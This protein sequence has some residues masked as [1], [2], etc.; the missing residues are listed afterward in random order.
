MWVL[1]LTVGCG[2]DADTGGGTTSTGQGTTEPTAGPDRPT[3]EATTG[4]EPTTVD[5]SG[6]SSGAPGTDGT[7][8]AAEPDAVALYVSSG[9]VVH[10]FD[11]DLDTGA[12]LLGDSLEI[13]GDVGAMTHDA[14]RARLYVAV[15]SDEA[16][17]CWAIAPDGALSEVAQTS[18]GMNAVYLSLS[19]SAPHLL[20]ADFGADVVA[21]FAVGG[22]G[23]V[24]GAAITTLG[25]GSQP[26]SIVL[27]PDRR[28]AFVPHL[29]GNQIRQLGFDG[30]TG[31]LVPNDPAQVAPQDGAGP[32]HMV[33]AP[34]GRVAWVGN[35]LDDTIT[36]WTY[37]A[38]LGQLTMPQ[39]ISTLPEGAD[40]SDSYVGD[41]HV[42]P[43]G[44]FVYVSN[45][46]H[47]TLA[48]FAVDPAGA[49]TPIGHAA[50][51]PHVRDFAIEPN[52]RFLFAAG[53]DSGQLAGYAIGDDGQLTAL[54]TTAAPPAPVWVEAVAVGG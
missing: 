13:G 42:T 27:A 31:A 19:E 12:L 53:R 49:L 44:R 14:A 5:T 8:T 51:E 36:T 3:T 52:G 20:V 40:G 50:T 21:S 38:A 29:G 33:F 32:R 16:I 43:D 25:V 47:D 34:D 35:E 39:S 9:T 48:M 54:G 22:D 37:D 46:G 2:A 1:V 10:R 11:V 17:G 24:M 28:F 4:V 23:A 7:T 41:V 6:G 26:H 45:R 30:T 18:V 15:M